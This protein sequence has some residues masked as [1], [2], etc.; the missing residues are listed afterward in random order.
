MFD[1]PRGFV[2]IC[3][4]PPSLARGARQGRCWWRRQGGPAPIQEIRVERRKFV[5][6]QFP[7]PSRLRRAP[8]L[9]FSCIVA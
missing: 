6:A 8:P 5:S 4:G 9:S 3:A 2:G 1:G 7:S